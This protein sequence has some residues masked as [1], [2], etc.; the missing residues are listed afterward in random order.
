[1]STTLGFHDIQSAWRQLYPI[2]EKSAFYFL[3]V[4]SLL[5]YWNHTW[6]KL[7]S[8]AFL[9]FKTIKVQVDTKVCKKSSK[10]IHGNAIA[11]V[12]LLGCTGS[13]IILNILQ[14]QGHIL[15][16]CNIFSL[17]LIC[18]FIVVIICKTVPT[19]EFS[20]TLENERLRG[21]NWERE[22]RLDYILWY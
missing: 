15:E 21:S 19:Y 8:I 11:Y 2:E 5:K 9:T 3:S 6:I 1:M 22:E 7:Q 12:T 16:W 18:C 17:L 13:L 10:W 14:C 4:F 20:Y